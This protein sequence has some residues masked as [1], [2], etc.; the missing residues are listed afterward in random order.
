VMRQLL[1]IPNRRVRHL[2]TPLGC[3]SIRQR[4]SDHSAWPIVKGV[5]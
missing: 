4:R 1:K 3:L 5:S 2:S